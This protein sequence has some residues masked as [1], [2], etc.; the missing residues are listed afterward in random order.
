[1]G[2]LCCAE[3]G[4]V[5]TGD[6]WAF[7]KERVMDAL[8]SLL[9]LLMVGTVPDLEDTFDRIDGEDD[10]DSLDGDGNA[11]SDE[12][13]DPDWAAFFAG[14][15][16]GDA[17]AA[18]AGET[19]GMAFL[20]RTDLPGGDLASWVDERPGDMPGPDLLGA[21]DDDAFVSDTFV[22][23]AGT[24]A[25]AAGLGLENLFDRDDDGPDLIEAY[26]EREDALFVVYD[27]AAH[28]DPVLS[29]GPS[30][31]GDADAML[32]LDGM[33]I[34]VVSGGASLSLD[35]VSLVPDTALGDLL[36]A[37]A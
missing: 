26:D 27:A 21:I 25:L 22:S 15:E 34:A 1:M 9:G 8:G 30:E 23:G 24:S 28:P 5:R 17:P 37:G 11:L 20:G 31:T 2:C 7:R 13:I 18:P 10:G 32:M 12:G 33:P 36:A 16:S 19:G 4:V 6:E 14:P 35:A 3:V 29:I